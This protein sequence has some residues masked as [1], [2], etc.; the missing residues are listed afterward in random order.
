MQGNLNVSTAQKKYDPQDDDYDELTE[1][2][3]NADDEVVA[4]YA[5]KWMMDSIGS[6]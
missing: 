1:S 2:D 3:G 6:T 4:A 5:E